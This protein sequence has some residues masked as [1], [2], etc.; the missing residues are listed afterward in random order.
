MTSA[1]LNIVHHHAPL[2]IP[3][4]PAAVVDQNGF[5]AL[6]TVGQVITLPKGG[7]LFSPGDQ[8]DH[9]FQV[10]SGMLRIYTSLPN[11]RRQIER[12][13]VPGDLIGLEAGDV[14][15]TTADAVT[16][17]VVVRYCRAR[18]DGVADND[19]RLAWTFLRLSVRELCKAHRRLV[20]VGR[21]TAI[22]RLAFFIVEM[23]ERSESRRHIHL[24]MSRMDIADYL[25]LTIETVSRVF[26]KL[27]KDG[28][29]RLPSASR[30]EV[31]DFQS[32]K[33]LAE[34]FESH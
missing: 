3:V 26:T 29:V 31:Q 20:L 30:L 13:A 34:G 23:M 21:N 14:H 8:A 5:E 7:S 19:A 25:G 33:E 24:P 22:E 32:L 28:I 11:G 15:A 4:P 16:E 1:A 27:C 12:F 6:A 17:S 18:A 10:R 2:A 9:L